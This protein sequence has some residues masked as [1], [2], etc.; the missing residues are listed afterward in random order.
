MLQNI[1]EII[2]IINSIFFGSDSMK[3]MAYET[4]CV[5]ISTSFR[6]SFSEKQADQ[7]LQYLLEAEFSKDW[8]KAVQLNEQKYIRVCGGHKLKDLFAAAAQRVAQL[9]QN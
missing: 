3:T 1:P 9:R 2:R 4:L 6:T 8:I 5:K 7:H